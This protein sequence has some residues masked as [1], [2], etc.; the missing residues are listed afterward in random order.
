[1]L[2]LKGRSLALS[3]ASS[4]N[5]GI[6]LDLSRHLNTVRIDP[7]KKIAFVGGG[8]VWR[9]VD[10]EAIKYGLATPSG[11]YNDTGVGG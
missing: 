6:V 8:C 10:S 2:F 7:E 9:Q 11:V 3:Q 1:M 5:G 4:T